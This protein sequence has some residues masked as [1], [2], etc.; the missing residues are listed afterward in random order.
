MLGAQRSGRGP[1]P[2]PET[3]GVPLS[4]VSGVPVL[5]LHAESQQCSGVGVTC[6]HAFT[7][8]LLSEAR[9]CP[10]LEVWDA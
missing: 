1:T 2:P 4:V 9:R 6:S 5:A 7:H 3:F 8:S 10:P